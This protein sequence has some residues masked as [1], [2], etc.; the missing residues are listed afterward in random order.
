M[1][2]SCY[3]GAGKSLAQMLDALTSEE[4]E[5]SLRSASAQWSDGTDAK[6]HAAQ[7]ISQFHPNHKLQVI[8]GLSPLDRAAA[9]GVMKQKHRRT[10]MGLLKGDSAAATLPFVVR[11]ISQKSSKLIASKG[12]EGQNDGKVGLEGRGGGT[13][14]YGVKGGV[15]NR[16]RVMIQQDALNEDIIT[17]VCISMVLNMGFFAVRREL[18]IT[19]NPQLKRG[20]SAAWHSCLFGFAVMN[21][22]IDIITS[23]YTV[24]AI[25][26]KN[27]AF[28]NI[29]LT[30]AIASGLYNFGNYFFDQYITN[31]VNAFK[32]TGNLDA[33]ENVSLSALRLI[34]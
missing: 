11:E 30:L 2:L 17:I 29:N 13:R 5:A 24:D 33:K 16:G 20:W 22:L 32:A 3:R 14:G 19:E 15:R 18:E 9:F 4:R 25:T 7:I 23:R 31:S 8:V 21:Y 28:G 26:I 10:A 34:Y 12:K 27:H 1:P 6:D